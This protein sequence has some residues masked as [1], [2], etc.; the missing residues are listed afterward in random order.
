MENKILMADQGGMSDGNTGQQGDKKE[1]QN[2]PD[3]ANDKK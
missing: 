3:A 1:G 2:Q